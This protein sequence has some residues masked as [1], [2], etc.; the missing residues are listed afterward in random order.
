MKQ[1]II[2]LTAALL[3]ILLLPT[4][5]L[6]RGAMLP[7]FYHD[8]YYAVLDRMHTRL[9]TA[10]GKKLVIVGGSNVAF[11]LDGA[12][13][14]ELLAQKGFDYTVCPFGLYAAVG[15]AAMLDLSVDA[16]GEGDIVILAVEP[17]SETMS[18]YFG[19]TAFWKC[20][21]DAPHLLSRLSRARQAAMAGNYIAFLQERLAIEASGQPPIAQGVYAASSFNDRCD[22]IFERPGNV[23]A[24][25]YDTAARVELD[26]VQISPAFAEQVNDYCAA[27]RRKGAQVLL[28]FSPVN[29]SAMARE[30]AKEFFALCNQALD[31]TAI[32]D[33]NR[34]IL[35]SGWFYDSNFHLNSAGAAVRTA[36]LA[37]DL[38]TYLGC[39]E[40]LDWSSPEMPP[41]AVRYTGSGGDADAFIYEHVAGGGLVI[42]GLTD[43]G[44]AKTMLTVPSLVDGKPVVGFIPGALDGAAAEEIRLP[45]SIEGLPDGLFGRCE[46]LQR[47]ILEHTTA[48]CSI[49]EETFAGAEELRILVPREVWAM[50]R[51]G[52]GC[53]RNPWEP[54]LDRI[55]PY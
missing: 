12:L 52:Y 27:A 10:A 31:C 45:Q 7:S 37:E 20:A 35:D 49:T 5:L 36:M 8:S 23:M 51:D 9:E 39:Y 40:P 18:D 34:Y 24:L 32:S 16:L 6:L 29:R 11:G 22:L 28:S 14:E 38:L 25:G 17:T 4:A 13:L 42:G 46:S 50:Y 53:E 1:H 21:E 43:P 2:K 26:T 48:P 3:L 15:T 33:P 19:A 47:L 44:A 30:E 41:S 54:Y 55:I